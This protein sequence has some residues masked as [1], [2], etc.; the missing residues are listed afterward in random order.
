MD[1][2]S[3][4]R[5]EIGLGAGWLATDYQQSGIRYDSNK[6]RVDR[7]EEGLAVIKRA[8]SG[9]PFSF[10]GRHYTITDYTGGPRPVQAPYPPILVGGGGPR[11]LSIAGVRPTSSAST[12]TSAP[13]QSDRRRSNR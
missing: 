12:G 2:L 6:V 10:S 4:G 3:G 11:V 5:L 7:F 8:M 9:E 1:V 13:V